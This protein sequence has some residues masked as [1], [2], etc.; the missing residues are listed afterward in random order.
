MVTINGLLKTTMIDYPGK[1]AAAVF[2][3][4]CN[5][6]C[7]FC[8]N[9]DLVKASNLETISEDE[10][11]SFLK[12]RKK[13]VDGL[14]ISGGE[15]TIHKD[16]PEFAKRVKDAGFLVKIDTNGGMPD[17]LKELV[18]KKLVDYIAMDIKSSP[19]GYDKA[20]GTKVDIKAIEKSI[21]IIRESGIDYE[22]RTTV[23]PGIH[24]KD[25]I[26]KIG[27]WLK[28]SKKYY[29]QQ[30]RSEETLDPKMKGKPTFSEDDLKEMADLVS[31]DFDAVEIRD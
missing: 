31:G 14:V 18:S 15:P 12:E 16:L 26:K 7:P 3:G 11:I 24:K 13:W 5:F 30:F 4:G 9:I 23:V 8:H 27:E 20:S 25:D 22:F 1:M 19:Q 6:K 17:I 21:K 10:V 29:I 2:L 28:G